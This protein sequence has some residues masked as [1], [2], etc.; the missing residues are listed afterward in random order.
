MDA[1]SATIVASKCA[2]IQLNIRSIK[3]I[4]SNKT[5]QQWPRNEHVQGRPTLRQCGFIKSS[6]LEGWAASPPWLWCLLD[7]LWVVEGLVTSRAHHM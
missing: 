1:V 2:L 3:N 4:D 7:W 6:L 5:L